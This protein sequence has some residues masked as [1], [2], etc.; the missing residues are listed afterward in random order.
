LARHPRIVAVK[1]ATGSLGRAQ[2]TLNSCP[3]E[4][5]LHSALGR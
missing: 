4:F 2:E 3:P 5:I 1:E